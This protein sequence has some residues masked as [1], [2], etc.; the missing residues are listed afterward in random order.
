M[1]FKFAFCFGF[2]HKKYVHLTVFLKKTPVN[3]YY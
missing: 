1:R 3:K 2:L